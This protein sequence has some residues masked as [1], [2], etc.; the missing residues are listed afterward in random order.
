MHN[1]WTG[2]TGDLTGHNEL[3]P[4]LSEASCL[5]FLTD[6]LPQ[7][8]EYV[9]LVTRQSMWFMHDGSPAT[10]IGDVKQIL[11]SHCPDRWIGP[12]L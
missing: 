11:D 4:R 3:P 1:V 10:F 7:I 6:K 5:N 2:I 12:V 8:L 9:P